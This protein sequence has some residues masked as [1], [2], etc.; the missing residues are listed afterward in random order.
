MQYWMIYSPDHPFRDGDGYVM[1]Q[2]LV[3]EKKLGRYLKPTEIVHHN[4]VLK[5]SRGQHV[6]DHFKAGHLAGALKIENA[7]LKRLLKTHGISPGG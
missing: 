2:R 5:R 7:M 1:E 3:M 4:L 6:R